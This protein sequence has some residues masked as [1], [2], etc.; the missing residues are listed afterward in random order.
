MSFDRTGDADLEGVGDVAVAASLLKLWLRQ[1]PEPLI[2]SHVATELL[3]IHESKFLTVSILC[4]VACRTIHCF[5]FVVVK[6][7]W[8]EWLIALPFRCY[9]LR[10]GGA[11]SPWALYAV[12]AYT[13]YCSFQVTVKRNRMA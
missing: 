8:P 4:T 12:M 11:F 10:K 7:K 1:L 3:D 9:S 5:Y 13:H 6:L 2:A